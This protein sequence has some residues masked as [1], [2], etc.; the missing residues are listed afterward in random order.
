[1]LLELS[2]RDFALIDAIEISFGEGLTALTGETGAGKSILVE[3]LGCACGARARDEWVREGAERAQLSALFRIA[4]SDPLLARLGEAGIDADGGEL[5]LRREIVA[6]G[7]G[8]AWANGVPVTLAQLRAIGEGLVDLHSQHE[9]QSLLRPERHLEL[10][11][12]F[13]GLDAARAEVASAFDARAEARARLAGES[14]R[15]AGVRARREAIERELREIDAVDPKPGEE[16]RLEAEQLALTHRSKLLA[17]LDRAGEALSDGEAA[18]TERAG[19]AL[20]ALRDGAPFDPALAEAADLVSSGLVAL[21]EAAALV[22]ARRGRL[23]DVEGSVDALIGRIEA[24]ARL[25]KRHGGTLDAVLSR[26]AVLAA[27]LDLAARGE[28]RLDDLR[29]EAAGVDRTLGARALA[30]SRERARAASRLAAAVSA[31]LRGLGMRAAAFV[32]EVAQEPAAD[33]IADR[34]K[35]LWTSR[36]GV[37]KVAFHLEPNPGE[38]RHPL[39]RIASGGELSR[40]LLALIATLG[41]GRGAPVSIFDEVDTGV[42]ADA[43]AAIGERLRAAARGR[44]VLVIT[45]FA[46]IAAIAGRHVKIAKVVRAGRTRIGAETLDGEART[47]EIARMLGGE[48]RAAREHAEAILARPDAARAHSAQRSPRAGSGS[49]SGGRRG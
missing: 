18:A 31:E 17:I 22:A 35:I 47:E 7:R 32:V 46:Q 41:G 49:S 38:G 42:G 10:L 44:Q 2:I 26:R 14:A 8:R 21:N 11:D 48:G 25:R 43:A 30:L 5:L 9:S 24:I 19:R 6:G 20:R 12:A 29:R 27:D 36:T 1:M 37:D 34:G 4:A 23:A 3:A 13:G 33:G 39:A 28:D 16:E 45:H 40:V 15:L